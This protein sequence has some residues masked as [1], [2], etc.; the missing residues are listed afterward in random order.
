MN[1]KYVIITDH[2]FSDPMSKE[3]A[4]KSVKEY[5]S[6]GVIGYIVSE[7]EA[8]KIGTPENFYSPKLY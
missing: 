8:N 3:N 1:K 6:K 4:I 7:E 5:D 2:E